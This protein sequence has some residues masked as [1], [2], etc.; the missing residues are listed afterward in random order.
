MVNEI[1]N[2]IE[3]IRNKVLKNCGKSDYKDLTVLDFKH[4]CFNSDDYYFYFDNIDQRIHWDD[5]YLNKQKLEKCIDINDNISIVPLS[6][7]R[8]LASIDWWRKLP[9]T[10]YVYGETNKEMLCNK[11]RIYNNGFIENDKPFQHLEC[12][13]ILQIWE[14]ECVVSI[15]GWRIYKK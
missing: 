6:D 11:Y 4:N 14:K 2:R 10:S 7:K 1:K 3:A 15:D 12:N 9:D 5:D 13:E 8:K